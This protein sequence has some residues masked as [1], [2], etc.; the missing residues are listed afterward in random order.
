M[1]CD[2]IVAEDLTVT[3]SIGVVTAKFN[4]KELFGKIGYNVELLS[5]GRFAELLTTSREFTAEEQ[6]Y[7]EQN[8]RQA[9]Q[10]FVAKAA[11][12]RSKSVEELDKVAQGRV[13]TGRQAL[14]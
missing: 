4:A 11:A 7:F 14:Q 10:S 12:S 13:W 3:G 1:A 2:V 5:R 9:Y 8:A 6:K